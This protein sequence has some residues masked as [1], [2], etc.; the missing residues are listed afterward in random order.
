MRR[1]RDREGR[2]Q[3]EFVQGSQFDELG[4]K[5]VT[6]TDDTMRGKSSVSIYASH[7]VYVP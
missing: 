4:G 3:V 1:C 6:M 7:S 2:G 5:A